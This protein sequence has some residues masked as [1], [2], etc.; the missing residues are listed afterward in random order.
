MLQFKPRQSKIEDAPARW[1]IG[2][3]RR[4]V[5]VY[6]GLA[7]VAGLA[8]GFALGR[9]ITRKEAPALPLA[10]DTRAPSRP[11]PTDPSLE[12]HTVTRLLRADTI[13][14]DTVGP[15]HML[16]IE[17]PDGK[18]PTEIYGVH[19]QRAVSYIEKTLLGQAVRLEYDTTSHSNK[20][21]SGQTLAYVYTRDGLLINA[22]MVR[23]G[24][25]FV[26]GAE[27]TRLASDFRALEREAMQSM[28]GVWGPASPALTA[29]A[30]T[31]PAVTAATPPAEDKPKKLSP[32]PPSALGANI[33]A[34]SGSQG[35][36]LEPWVWVSP[37]DKMYHKSGCAFLDKK[38]HSIPLSEAK[39]QG[40]TACS[41]CYASTLLKAP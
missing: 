35:S 27:Q 13:E 33:P 11:P 18:T 23:Q 10:G 1:R 2:V 25:A 32:L 22:E 6:V 31:P 14:V 28:R 12:F 15:V 17:T 39:S 20:D 38:K 19:G 5:A 40:Y 37:S 29:P 30:I 36:S 16:G 8:T 7:I 34:L 3:D 24:L 26:H 4:H 21:D 41:R 9:Y